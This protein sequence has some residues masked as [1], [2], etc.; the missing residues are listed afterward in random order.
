G[1][2]K[3]RKA[4]RLAEN[5]AVQLQSLVRQTVPEGLLRID[6]QRALERLWL[7]PV[8]THV[9]AGALDLLIDDGSEDSRLRGEAGVK[10]AL[11][12]SRGSG[13]FGN[14]RGT[15]PLH[16]EAL[17][18][19]SNQ[20]SIEVGNTSGFGTSPCAAGLYLDLLHA[21]YS[22]YH[23]GCPIRSTLRAGAR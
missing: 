20:G 22:S 11:G 23:V 7:R 21:R 5:Q 1:F 13:D 10:R 4:L 16:H 9:A 18:C 12:S 15:V 19:Y 6:T 17:A 3:L 14:R 8:L 2:R